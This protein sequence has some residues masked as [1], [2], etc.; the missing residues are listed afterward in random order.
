MSKIKQ[1]AMAKQRRT[2]RVRSRLMGTAQRPRL[3][4]SISTHHVRAQII[5]DT[6]AK[7]LVAV[8][9][10]KQ[11]LPA[12]LSERSKWAGAE[13]AKKAQVAKIKHVV[14][15]RRH[16]PYHGRVQ[17]FAEAARSGGLEF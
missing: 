15:D 6:A 5:D 1:I 10:L 11:K 8:S 4:I 7:T 14:F 3:A 12:T 13:L 2:N 9:T 17:A 16:K